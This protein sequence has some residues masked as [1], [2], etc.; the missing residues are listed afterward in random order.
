MSFNSGPVKVSS[1]STAVSDGSRRTGRRSPFSKVTGLLG[2][3][4]FPPQT[5]RP[6]FCSRAPK[7]VKVSSTFSKVAGVRGRRPRGL[8]PE[9]QKFA[10]W[11]GWRLP[12]L[13]G[14]MRPEPFGGIFLRTAKRL[15]RP[16]WAISGLPRGTQTL[17][18]RLVLSWPP[19]RRICAGQ[20]KK[21]KKFVQGLQKPRKHGNIKKS[22]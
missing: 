13:P 8:A 5:E 1:F 11:E 20:R 22:D 10:P 2:S 4:S 18:C 6:A 7:R 21:E 19:G 16:G 12:A 15:F 9:A 14:G 17:T 3:Y